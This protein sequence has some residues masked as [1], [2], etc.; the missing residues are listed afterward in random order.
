M[1]N[2]IRL[3]LFYTRKPQT[4]RNKQKPTEKHTKTH[5]HTHTQKKTHK[6]TQ[7]HTK[8]IIPAKDPN[9]GVFGIQSGKSSKSMYRLS[10]PV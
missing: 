10:T 3:I 1:K 4:H 7:K 6:F 8:N 9:R 2:K 5:K